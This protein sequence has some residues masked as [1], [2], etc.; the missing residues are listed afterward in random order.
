M[1]RDLV[2]SFEGG[3]PPVT[4]DREAFLR[5]R[6]S[7][8]VKPGGHVTVYLAAGTPLVVLQRDLLQFTSAVA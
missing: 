4:S 2:P 8:D 7:D 1:N 3:A 5:V 6:V